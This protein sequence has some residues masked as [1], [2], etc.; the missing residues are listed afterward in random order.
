VTAGK[1]LGFRPAIDGLAADFA[2]IICKFRFH[3]LGFLS[4]EYN[5]RLF[6]LASVPRD[7]VRRIV[8]L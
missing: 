5:W 3:W 2:S 8:R 4:H 7:P 6:A 1:Y